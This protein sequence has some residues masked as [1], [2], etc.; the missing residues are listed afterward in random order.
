[1]VKKDIK[2]QL[3][4]LKI[5][6]LKSSDKSKRYKE[7]THILLDDGKTVLFLEEQDYYIYHD[8]D[9][10][11]KVIH[12]LVDDMLWKTVNSWPDATEDFI[13]Y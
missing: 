9:S 10:S 2:M 6:A 11:A 1:M 12:C 5:V 3:L 13:K 4:G 7:I 8:A